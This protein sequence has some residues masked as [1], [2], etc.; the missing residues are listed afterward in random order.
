[1]GELLYTPPIIEPGSDLLTPALIHDAANSITEAGHPAE[2]YPG[3][4]PGE[5]PTRLF[6]HPSEVH[7]ITTFDETYLRSSGCPVTINRVC[8]PGGHDA[9][10]PGRSAFLHDAVDL[11]YTPQPDI[12]TGGEEQVP[13]ED[14]QQYIDAGYTVFD[15]H[16]RP[17]PG[18][19]DR[20][21]QLLGLRSNGRPIGMPTGNG[22]FV[23]PGNHPAVDVFAL[24]PGASGS[25]DLAVLLYGR[26]RSD[27]SPAVWAPPGGFGNASDI[28]PI[29]SRY[30][31]KQSAKRHAQNPDKAG[32][33]LK[34]LDVRHLRHVHTEYA[35]SSHTTIN[36]NLVTQ[37]FL[38]RVPYSRSNGEDTMHE[39]PTGE[40]I[41]GVAWIAV[42]AL[43]KADTEMR[44]KAA[45]GSFEE[46]YIM[47]S[48][49][50]RGL[51]AAVNTY[52]SMTKKRS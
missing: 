39:V 18:T 10:S 25:Q 14:F 31:A 33:A 27:Q 11:L 19:Y 44:K 16:N 42:S 29:S 28:G 46:P 51:I 1:M 38:Y 21:V 23:A 7:A 2:G 9:V 3:F 5:G 22:S 49:H 6:M 48:A 52:R 41:R 30:D 8:L 15:Q 12:A 45:R 40:A 36:A 32:E 24:R 13:E 35:I 17:M 34:D 26:P 4:I 20:V 47:W 50:M 43:I 37:N